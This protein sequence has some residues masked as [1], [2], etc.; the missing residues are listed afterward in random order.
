MKIIRIFLFFTLITLIFF[1]LQSCDETIITYTDHKGQTRMAAAEQGD[2]ESETGIGYQHTLFDSADQKCQHCHNELYDTWKTSMHAKSW[3]DPIFQSAHQDF[4]RTHITKI[5]TNPTGEREYTTTTFKGAAKTC[6]KCHAPAALYSGD[7]QVSIDPLPISGSIATTKEFTKAKAVHEVN[8][9][10]TSQ[11]DPTCPTTVV[12]TGADGKLYKATYHIGNPANQE[13]IN[14]ATCHTIETVRMMSEGGAD[15]GIYTLTKDL[16]AGPHGPV[17]KASGDTLVYDADGTNTDMNYFFR[18][19]GP[20]IYTDYHNTPKSIGEFDG[21]NGNTKQS[22]GRF[23]FTNRDIS[24]PEG[25]RHYTGGPFYG[26]FGYTGLINSNADDATDRTAHLNPNFDKDNN[27]HFGNYGT[28]LCLSCHQRSAG[29]FSQN[30]GFMELCTPWLAVSDGVG[31]NYEDTDTSPK[32]QYCHMPRLADKRVLHQWAKPNK[33]FTRDDLDLTPHFDPDNNK[34]DA[35]NNPVIGEWLSDHGFTGANQTGSSNFLAK[36]K[37]GFEANLK[38]TANDGVLNVT[39]MLKNKTAH[40]FP[41]SHLTRRVLSRVVVTNNKGEKV[42]FSGATGIST[43]DTIENNVVTGDKHDTIDVTGN[44]IVTVGYDSR[45]SIT[46]QGQVPDLDGSAVASQQFS[47]TEVTVTAPD[48]AVKNQT[49]D[50]NG[51]IVGT[52]TNTA[53]VDNSDAQHFTRIYGHETGKMVNGEF[54]VR[55][56]FG[57]NIV[58]NDNR[59]LPNE[60]ETY[61]LTYDDLNSGMYTV[62]YKIYYLQKGANGKFPTNA[63]GFLDNKENIKKKLLISEVGSYSERIVVE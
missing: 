62:T 47:G 59:L 54:V 31:N 21:G 55:P 18:L 15:G 50:E 58:G 60:T 41:G 24:D 63:D 56:G 35:T 27:N 42:S 26:P 46:F 25:K 53:I 8:L 22:D 30:D 34:T 36:I 32:C 1:F 10:S 51:K 4:F 20:E 33:L 11:Y 49:L 19:W 52:L 29:S 40:M 3:S 43:F 48:K 23:V 57:S 5:G 45:R 61:N 17:K 9:A 28:A 39:T 7:Y 2:A 16:R 44:A 12:A 6:I 37:S 13:G 38:T 14:C